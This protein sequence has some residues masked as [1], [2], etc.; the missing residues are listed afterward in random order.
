MHFS[1]SEGNF[2]LRRPIFSMTKKFIMPNKGIKTRKV[3]GLDM[4]MANTLLKL[5][6]G[7]Q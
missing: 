5:N 1:V 7:F 6:N 3:G 2:S 4:K